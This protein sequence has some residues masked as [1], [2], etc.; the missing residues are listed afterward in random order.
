M[1]S[2]PNSN[3]PHPG[4]EPPGQAPDSG[5][6]ES[7]AFASAESPAPNGR[8]A[9]TAVLRELPSTPSAVALLK[10]LRRHWLRALCVAVVCASVAALA[11]WFIMPAPKY[12][13]RALLYMASFQPNVLFRTSED[14]ADNTTYQRTQ[15]ALIKGRFVL[16]AAL[17]QPKV[18]DLSLVREQP[19][20]AG[21]LE[22]D[23]KVETIGPELV[24]ISLDGDRPDELTV[25][26]N[27]V[28]QA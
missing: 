22:S 15:T 24:R 5:S 1:A 16:N 23:L 6:V 20:A 2:S 9:A 4:N 17:R 25:I 3:T 21:W 27:A 10:A 26:V 18:S 13:S 14:H 12:S 8:P 7:P 11:T 28:T 19:D